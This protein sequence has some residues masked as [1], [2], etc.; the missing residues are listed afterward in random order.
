MKKL[1]IEEGLLLTDMILTFR[2]QSLLLDR[3]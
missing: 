3:V 2:E 1:I